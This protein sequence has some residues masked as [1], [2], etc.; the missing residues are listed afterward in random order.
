MVVTDTPPTAYFIPS[1]L[2]EQAKS[3]PL[4]ISFD[5]G[6]DGGRSFW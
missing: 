5:G 6:F 2:S 1:A 3:N 4:T